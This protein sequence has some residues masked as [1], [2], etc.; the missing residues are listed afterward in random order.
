M[1]QVYCGIL[2]MSEVFWHP[3]SVAEYLLVVAAP[4]A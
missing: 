3:M 4:A 1:L 2:N